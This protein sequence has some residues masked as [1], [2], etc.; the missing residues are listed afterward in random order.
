MNRSYRN[1]ASKFKPSLKPYYLIWD[2]WCSWVFFPFPN[3]CLLPEESNFNLVWIAWKPSA[4]PSRGG[5]KNK[6]SLLKSSVGTL[7]CQA[8]E[9]RR[10]QR[11]V[12]TI[13]QMSIPKLQSGTR[14]CNC[15]D[16]RPFVLLQLQLFF[17][18]PHQPS[19]ALQNHLLY[20]HVR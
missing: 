17:P 15:V 7:V 11:W 8:L 4:G 6:R 1:N 13:V 14:D 18:I 20:L 16:T 5:N 12:G 9:G 19:L 10:W 2:A 3:H